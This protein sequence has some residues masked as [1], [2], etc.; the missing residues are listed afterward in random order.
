MVKRKVF[1]LSL[2]LTNSM[3]RI[4]PFS[5]PNVGEKIWCGHISKWM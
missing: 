2:A 1:I 3:V 5:M 4:L